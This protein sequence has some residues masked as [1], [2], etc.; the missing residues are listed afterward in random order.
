MFIWWPDS[1]EDCWNLCVQ[2]WKPNINNLE[3]EEKKTLFRLTRLMILLKTKLNFQNL[4]IPASYQCW[5]IQEKIENLICH[6]QTELSTQEGKERELLEWKIIWNLIWTWNTF[7]VHTAVAALCCKSF[8]SMQQHKSR[9]LLASS[10]FIPESEL[11]ENF[12][13]FSFPQQPAHQRRLKPFAITPPWTMKVW[14]FGGISPHE[15]SSRQR[16]SS[17]LQVIS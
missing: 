10:E 13:R 4:L 8:K 1:R 16:C 3:K 6:S 7:I 12:S 17:A 2:N 5:F 14:V 9:L 11:K 15:S